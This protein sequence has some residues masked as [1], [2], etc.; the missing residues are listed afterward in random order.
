MSENFI[1]LVGNVMDGIRFYGPFD[2]LDDAQEY[3]KRFFKLE[4][5]SITIP[6]KPECY[7]DG[8]WRAPRCC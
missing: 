6:T 1:I 2:T 4:D 3:A 5:W 8:S 7:D